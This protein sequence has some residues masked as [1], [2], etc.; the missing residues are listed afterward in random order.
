[1][2]L[3]AFSLACSV[4][5]A[6]TPEALQQI[7]E[8]ST[9]EHLPDFEA[10]EARRARRVDGADRMMIREGG[11]AVLPVVGPIFRYANLF[12][13]FSGGAAVSTLARDFNAALT[14]PNV[15]AILLNIDSP[16]GEVAGISE[17]AQM[18]FDARGRKPI[19]AY[20][21]SLGA[22]AAYWIASA[23]DEIVAD[24]T[25]MIGSIGVVAAVPNPQARSAREIQFV[26]SQSPKKR[27]DPTTESGRGQIQTLVD[28]LADV[29]IQTVAR[30]RGVSASTVMRD[31][32]A[33]AVLV[34]Q[35]AVDAGLADRL[36]SFELM[37]SESAQGKKPR[38]FKLNMEDDMKASEILTRIK[39]LLP[40]GD[41]REEKAPAAGDDVENE[42]LRKELADLLK[43]RIESEAKA[44]VDAQLAASRLLPAEAEGAVADYLQAAADDAAMP[45]ASG[46]RV[47]RLRQRIE[48]RPSHKLTQ[49]LVINGR[50]HRVIKADENDQTEVSEERRRELLAKTG[51]GRAALRSINQLKGV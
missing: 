21:D 12:T 42:Q 30:N 39:A 49:E 31:F 48:A 22:S 33:G 43:Q 16:G 29:F 3:R 2:A 50:D 38:G 15:S 36:G 11:V 46:S 8:I 5:W 28:D 35:K 10:V 20:V 27:P 6:I 24:A 13:E 25:A 1:M 45:L 41:L 44:F 17:F 51:A 26:S 34:G 4:P 37:I 19:V 14:D 32:G 40:S 9:R 18:I 47:D 23:A 7:L